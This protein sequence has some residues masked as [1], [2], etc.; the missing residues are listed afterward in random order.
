[1]PDRGLDRQRKAMIRR[2][3][4]LSRELEELASPSALGK[5]TE[6]QARRE[7]IDVELQEIE[8]HLADLK[9][10]ERNIASME[11]RE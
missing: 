7:R 5:L 3:Q 6:L 10:D 1:M 11:G 8:A 9:V 4:E 2:R